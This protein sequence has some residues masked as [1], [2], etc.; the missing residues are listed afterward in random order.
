MTGAK[1]EAFIRTAANTGAIALK[2][3]SDENIRCRLVC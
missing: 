1:Y 3:S 2:I